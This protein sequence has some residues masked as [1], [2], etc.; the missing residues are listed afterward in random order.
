MLPAVL[1]FSFIETT[2]VSSVK[3]VA[4][5]ASRLIFSAAAIVYASQQPLLSGLLAFFF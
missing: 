3:T 5:T 4:I 1:R 2:P